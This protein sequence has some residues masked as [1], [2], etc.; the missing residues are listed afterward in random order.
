MDYVELM[1]SFVSEGIVL[2]Y[3]K[4][5]YEKDERIK[6]E[7]DIDGWNN[8]FFKLLKISIFIYIN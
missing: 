4:Y 2:E 6:Y 8:K 3:G 1:N 5:D 7:Y